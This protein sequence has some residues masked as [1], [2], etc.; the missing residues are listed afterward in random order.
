MVKNAVFYVF[1][2]VS[3]SSSFDKFF[4]KKRYLH[5]K[6]ASKKTFKLIYMNI[7]TITGIILDQIYG[8]IQLTEANTFKGAKK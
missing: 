6:M 7:L 2:E 3:L 8:C 1:R 5:V 4:I